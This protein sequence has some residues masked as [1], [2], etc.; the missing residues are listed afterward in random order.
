MRGDRCLVYGRDD[1]LAL[2]TPARPPSSQI[3]E[4]VRTLGLWSVCRLRH[5]DQCLRFHR[6][7]GRRSGRSRQPRP[8]LRSVGNGA[9]VI[10]TVR[11]TRPAAE[12]RPPPVLRSV[13]VDRHA[14]PTGSKLAFGCLNIRSVANK[15]DDLLDVRHDSAIDVLLLVETWHDADSVSF[16]RLRADGFQVVDR[17]R[18]RLRADTTSTNHGGVAVVAVNGVR[19]SSL[20]IGVK[21]ESFELLCVRVTSG[22]SS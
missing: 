2:Y 3:V 20:D 17:P 13:H 19:L 10:T 9:A 14:A 6:Y 16:R 15:L 21:P 7:R 8:I 12:Y 18:P 11:I 5:T 4:R 22:S 1:L